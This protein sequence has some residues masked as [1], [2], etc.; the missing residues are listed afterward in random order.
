MTSERR[1]RIR[2]ALDA[3]AEATGPDERAA[4]LGLIR[5][6]LDEDAAEAGAA[7]PAATVEALGRRVA[8][9]ERMVAGLARAAK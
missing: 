7:V 9:L 3:A 5:E 4:A 6:A 8:G 2:M 1:G